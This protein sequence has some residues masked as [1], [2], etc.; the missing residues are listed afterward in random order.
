MIN[1][2]RLYPPLRQCVAII[3][4][5]SSGTAFSDPTEDHRDAPHQYMEEIVV[6]APFG[7]TAA[8]TMQPINVL[9]GEA[10]LEEAAN[11]LGETLK[12]EIGINNASFGPGVGHPVVRGHTGNRVGILQNGVGTTDVSNQSADHA[13]GV[14]V[15]FA[16]RIE[17]IRGPASLLYG[18]GAIGGVINLIDGRIPETV[19]EKPQ[20]V[21]EQ[22]Y[23]D[24]NSEDRTVFRLDAGTGNFGFHLE[25]FRRDSDDVEISGYAID[26]AAIEAQEEL[27]HAHEGE[28]EAEHGDEHHDD[29]DEHGHEDEE[30]LP[31]TRGYI[32]NSDSESDG[33]SIGFSF[34]GERGFIG[35]STSTLNNEYGLPPGSHTHAHGDEEDEHH[36]DE[37]EHGDEHEDEHEDEG[38][39]DEDDDHGHG[40]EEVEFVR[41]DIEK[42]RY[43]L[44][45]GLDFDDGLI[46]S[47]KTSFAYTD[48]E[49]DEVEYFEDGGQV[50]GT[51]YSNE[52]YEGR[53]TVNRRATGAWSGIY[54]IQFTDNEF[55]AVGE[56]AFI[57]ES[58][59]RNFGVFG[60]EQF[61]GERFNL[62]LGFRYDSN[63][64]ETGQC[65][66]DESEFSASGSVLYRINDESNA[67]FGLT[68]AARTPSVEELFSNVDSNTCNRVAD[69][70]DLV[71]H[72][73]TNL[74][75]IGNPNL[76]TETSDNLEIGYRYHTGRITGEISAYINQIDDYI[77]LNITGEEFEEQLIA[78]H[79]ARD[80]EFKGIEARL[81]INVYESAPFGVNWSL[82]GDSVNADFDAGG[83]IPL[84]P[85]DK[86]GTEIEFYGPHWTFHIHMTSVSDQDDTGEFELPTD[87][88]DEISLYGDYHW[89]LGNAGELKVFVK[90][91]NLTDEEIR[92]HTSRLKNYAPEPGRS[93]LLGLRYTY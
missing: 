20:L 32:G 74:L 4:F 25:G 35:F 57:P 54:G 90:G 86:I 37:D 44:R 14:E 84:I 87:G 75:E 85:A 36:D 40:E 69:D 6:S 23:N 60:F 49:H 80:A 88:Y 24:N 77:F 58:D 78:E 8:E 41:L 89:D 30:E 19:P 66:S 27:L 22:T 39:A 51:T 68:R 43:D 61:E 63:E 79:T 83:D 31:N 9:A 42:T 34:V 92:N 12:G 38:H 55:S 17:I 45:A 64:A 28:H 46:E 5:T 53:M 10:L 15:S 73:A 33:G 70:E 3:L 11:T 26:E 71:L 18:S 13:E 48:Y 59:I 50:V 67:F 1:T 76:D 91:N 21:I 47:L 81:N 7:T 93:Y 56:E 72:A 62:E 29:E 82:F 52:G 16:D 65:D 2:N